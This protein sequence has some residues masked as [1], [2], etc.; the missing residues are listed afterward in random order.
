MCT[1]AQLTYGLDIIEVLQGFVEVTEV[2]GLG[3]RQRRDGLT[4][5]VKL[6]NAT[7]AAA[8]ASGQRPAALFQPHKAT[9]GE[10]DLYFKA[11]TG[12]NH[13]HTV[14][15]LRMRNDAFREGKTYG[16]QFQ[17]FRRSHHHHMR[18]PVVNQGNGDLFRQKIRRGM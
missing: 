2:E 16:E 6:F 4:D 14:D 17:I 13:I 10:F 11:I 5:I 1:A 3:K 7:H 9:T 12:L 8:G 18:N 15:L